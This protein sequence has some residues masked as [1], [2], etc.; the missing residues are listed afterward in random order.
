MQQ[1]AYL[2][3]PYFISNRVSRTYQMLKLWHLWT[4]FD[5]ET[6]KEK[7]KLNIYMKL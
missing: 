3:N 6:I 2:I 5:F 7:K 4:Y 1:L